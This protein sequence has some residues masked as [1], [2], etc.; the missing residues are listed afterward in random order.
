MAIGLMFPEIV[1]ADAHDE[2]NL[3]FAQTRKSHPA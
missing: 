3:E 1:R 2:V